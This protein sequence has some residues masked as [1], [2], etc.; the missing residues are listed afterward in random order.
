MKLKRIFAA[1]LT[2][3][4]LLSFAGCANTDTQGG[5][6]EPAGEQTTEERTTEPQTKED[7]SHCNRQN[8]L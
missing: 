8:A 7:G 1:V 3:A 2:A 6:S 4:M 5:S